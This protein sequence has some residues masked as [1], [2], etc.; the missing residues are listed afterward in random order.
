[1]NEKAEVK[2]SDAQNDSLAINFSKFYKIDAGL[3]IERILYV[4]KESYTNFMRM[5]IKERTP[6][7]QKSIF[8]MEFDSFKSPFDILSIVT[9]FKSPD[10]SCTL[11]EVLDKPNGAT[12]NVDM[13][14]GNNE[15]LSF[16]SY[17][18]AE[19]EVANR[20]I[21]EVSYGNAG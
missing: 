5:K 2:Y 21:G 4:T 15:K 10:F 18:K 9:N 1:V 7:E 14:M 3:K 6:F 8:P 16:D 20:L 13:L 12:L 17:F 19:N 11:V